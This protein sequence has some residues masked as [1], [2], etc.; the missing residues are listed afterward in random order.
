MGVL[1][2]VADTGIG[3]V[4]NCFTYRNEVQGTNNALLSTPANYASNAA[5]RARLIVIN[6]TYFNSSRLNTM[7][8]NDLQYA[9]R[10]ADDPGT[11]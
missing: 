7:T 4:D 1:Y 6:G 8:Q 9:L 11:I 2:Q 10:L 3:A 5:M